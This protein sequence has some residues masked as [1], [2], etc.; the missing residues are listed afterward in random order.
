[1]LIQRRVPDC[2]SDPKRD[3]YEAVVGC[4]VAGAVSGETKYGR[5]TGRG[6]SRAHQGQYLWTSGT[7]TNIMHLCRVLIILTW[8]ACAAPRRVVLTFEN[9]STVEDERFSGDNMTVVKR[10]GLRMLLAVQEEYVPPASGRLLYVEEDLPIVS[11]EDMVSGSTFDGLEPEEI[12]FQWNLFGETGL[13]INKENPPASSR[14][15]VIA[16]LVSG[17]NNYAGG[18]DFISD[19]ETA[20]DGDGCDTDASDQATVGKCNPTWHGTQMASV[21]RGS[22]S[23]GLSSVAAGSTL[24]SVRVLGKCDNGF[25]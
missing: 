7:T 13:G 20:M 17:F 11:S 5:E 6:R 3:D 23:L 25:A 18:Y 14:D 4:M 9:A 19:P 8:I 2:S 10:Y 15:T 12:P 24:L 1:M 22:Q 16:I 21:V